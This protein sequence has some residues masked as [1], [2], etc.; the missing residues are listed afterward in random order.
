MSANTNIK[1]LVK[2]LEKEKQVLLNVL[3]EHEKD[4]LCCLHRGCSQ[5][6]NRI[7][8]QQSN[9]VC[10]VD[11][12]EDV[13]MAPRSDELLP[14]KNTISLLNELKPDNHVKSAAMSTYSLSQQKY[15]IINTTRST[16]STVRCPPEGSGGSVRRES[17][18]DHRSA[19]RRLIPIVVS[20]M[21]EE[22]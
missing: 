10:R 1:Y 21:E 12:E 2:T 3:S 22:D 17:S 5:S 13:S 15:L 18:R 16:H 6:G 20:W 14:D 19:N 4:N 7:N 9:D 8:P 11:L